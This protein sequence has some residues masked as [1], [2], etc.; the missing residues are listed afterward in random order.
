MTRPQPRARHR[1]GMRD[2]RSGIRDSKRASRNSYPVARISY[3]VSHFS[4]P[5]SRTS[6]NPTWFVPVSGSP[7]PLPPA[8]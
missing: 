5:A 3:P 6:L 7:L 2:S 4:L 1:F 8:M